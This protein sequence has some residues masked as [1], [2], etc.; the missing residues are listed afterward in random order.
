[1]HSFLDA[2]TMAKTLRAALAE[3]SIAITHSDSLELV[4][5]QFGFKDWNTLS[6]QIDVASDA[7]VPLPRGWYR[8]S[9]VEPALYWSGPD[10]RE[11]GALHIASRAGAEAIGNRAGA[12]GQTI[13]PDDF[14][15]GL[16]RLAAELKGRN[17]DGAATIWMRID[18]DEPGKWLRFDNLIDR[19]GVGPLRGTFDWTRRNIVLDVPNE[20]QRIV[21]GILLK[22]TGEMWA[23]N[24]EVDA[25]P[26]GTARTDYPRRPWGFAGGVAA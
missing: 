9:T 14:R 26:P 12:L 2:K 23:R 3:R 16:V 20:A 10:E 7:F 18:S 8:T 13:L 21:F 25:A 22:G 24:I 11:G 17:C 4:A 1:M 5:R 6:A 19:D 15:G